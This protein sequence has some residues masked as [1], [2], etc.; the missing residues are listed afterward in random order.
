METGRARKGMPANSFIERSL[1]EPKVDKLFDLEIEPVNAGKGPLLLI[2]V[3]EVVPEGFKL[4]QEPE[5]CRVDDSFVTMKGNGLDPLKAEEKKLVL[6]SKVQGTFALKPTILN[7]DENGKYE[8][9][10]VEPVTITARELGIK[11]W[12]NVER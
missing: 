4:N 3:N 10:E 1:K 12:L 2:K 7:L 11:G 8:S 9:H 6:K 5:T